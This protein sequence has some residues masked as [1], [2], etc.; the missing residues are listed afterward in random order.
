MCSKIRFEMRFLVFFCSFSSLTVLLLTMASIFLNFSKWTAC[1]LH[2]RPAI[3]LICSFMLQYTSSSL[4][5]PGSCC[6]YPIV[7]PFILL[8]Q[9][10]LTEF[11][12]VCTYVLDFWRTHSFDPWLFNLMVRIMRY[13]FHCV[14]CIFSMFILLNI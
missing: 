1:L 5:Y 14:F 3:F 7:P 6:L 9:S 13:I 10:M 8:S 12:Y 4:R 2:V 11:L